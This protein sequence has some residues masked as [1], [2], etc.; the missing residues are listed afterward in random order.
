M[1]INNTLI[2]ETNEAAAD[3]VIINP[4]FKPPVSIKNEGRSFNWLLISLSRRLSE[5]LASSAN[6]IPKKSKLNDIGCQ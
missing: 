3:C 4:E 2:S 5:I 1:V 6:A